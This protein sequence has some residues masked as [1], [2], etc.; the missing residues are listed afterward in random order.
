MSDL[1]SLQPLDLSKMMSTE[2]QPFDFVLPGLL[3]STV[4][5][6][7]SAGGIGK[8]SFILQASIQVASGRDLLGLGSLPRGRVVLFSGED[9]PQPL[10]HRIY[11]LARHYSFSPNESEYIL[12]KLTIIPTVGVSVDLLSPVHQSWLRSHL[13]GCRLAVFD[14]LTRFHL[15]DENSAADA[16][17]VMATL[18]R[19]AFDSGCAIVF[20]HHVSK[21]S[22]TA[23]L[24]DQQQSARGSS[25][26][27]DNARWASFVLPMSVDD[28]E[29][30]N[31]SP[32]DRKKF[33][34]WN[35]AKQNYS[36][37]ISD[38]WLERRRGGVLERADFSSAV[39]K[40]QQYSMAKA[41]GGSNARL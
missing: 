14:T 40:A 7:F 31:V 4:G 16:K 9:G 13:T 28:A 3:G 18:E 30:F 6:L 21:S 2:P 39:S 12:D 33:I 37:P 41:K 34:R 8:S 35:I 1:S 17:M 32:V 22:A 26:F 29:R 38:V 10:H 36:S 27:V 5:L 15:V 11:A 19:L 23:G 25:V 20:L 24:A